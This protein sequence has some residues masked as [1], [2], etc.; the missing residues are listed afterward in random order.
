MMLSPIHQSSYSQ[1]LKV[2]HNFRG[3]NVGQLHIFK[4]DVEHT[5]VLPIQIPI[6][7]VDVLEEIDPQVIAKNILYLW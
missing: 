2:F 3:A 6:N 5:D 1:C 7:N 4:V